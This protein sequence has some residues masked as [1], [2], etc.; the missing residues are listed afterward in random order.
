[1]QVQCPNCGS[2]VEFPDY[3]AGLVENCPRCGRQM[4]LP[5][6]AA[7][8]PAPEEGPRRD[9]PP[10]EQREQLGWWDGLVGTVKGVFAAP[11]ET[12]AAMRLEG[13]GS[14]IGYVAICGGIGTTVSAV[15]G[16]LIAES[17]MKLLHGEQ[18]KG[19]TE[20]QR[21]LI[22]TI[23][24]GLYLGMIVLG[25]LLAIVGTFVGSAV[26]HLGLTIVNGAKRPF[27]ATFRAVAYATSTVNLLNVVP[28]VLVPILGPMVV[29]T[30]A[31]AIQTIAVAR[32][33]EI[34][35]G[36]ALVGILLIPVSLGLLCCCTCIGGLILIGAGAAA[37][38]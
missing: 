36:R 33:H 28:F 20:D 13:Y 2:V 37:H 23:L 15:W 38:G 24:T 21:V 27:E 10:W 12:F 5:A 26:C 34:S 18:L 32:T 9:G 4:Q 30:Y 16:M 17:Q 31:L 7:M 1:V 14:A 25:P 11:V 29:P 8:A 6:A 35:Y 22:G 19:L 3:R